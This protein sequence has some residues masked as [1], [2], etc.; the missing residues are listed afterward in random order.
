MRSYQNAYGL[1]EA[2]GI[3]NDVVLDKAE[4]LKETFGY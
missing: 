3:T 1:E 2:G 4:Y